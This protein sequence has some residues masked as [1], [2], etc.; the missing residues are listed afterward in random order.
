MNTINDIND[1]AA[2]DDFVTD[3]KAETLEMLDSIEPDLMTL[4]KEKG[5][6]SKE[7][8]N[9]IFR[10]IH[11]IKGGAGFSGFEALKSISHAMESIIIQ[12][13]EDRLTLNS[14]DIDVLLAAVDKIRTMISDIYNSDEISYDRELE[15][16]ERIAGR[17]ECKAAESGE[18]P[19][20]ERKE[21]EEL[22]AASDIPAHYE[23]EEDDDM[24]DEDLIKDFV[25]DIKDLLDSVEPDLLALEREREN[26]S[27]ELI[28]RVFRAM[29]S[30][31]GG[32]GFCGFEALKELS[33]A[34]ENVFMMIREEKMTLDPGKMDVLLSAID[35]IR[36]MI[37]RIQTSDQVPYV[38]ELEALNQ[39]LHEDHTA[40]SSKA[41]PPPEK[42]KT[43]NESEKDDAFEI[44]LDNQPRSV[45]EPVPAVNA[46]QSTE[47][48]K[49]P[50][51]SDTIRISVDLVDRLMNLAGE[52]VLG[53]NQL[54]QAIEGY[55]ADDPRINPIIQNVDVVTSEIQENIVQMRM[56]PVG[57]VLNKFPRTVRD[58]TRQMSKEAEMI[59]EG[60]EVELDKTILESLSNP[61]THLV[62][63]CV[64][65]GVES[66]AERLAAGKS[67]VGHIWLR[68][69]HEGGHVNIVLQDDGR[70][71]DSMRVGEIVIEK[72]MFSREQV[73]KM[74][75]SERLGLI[76]L[77]G[78]STAK[79]VTDISGRGVGMDVVKTNIERIGGH[80]DIESEIGKGTS[81]HI[82]IPLT[83]AIIPSLIVGVQNRR[84]AVPQINVQELVCVKAG[85]TS[86]QI[87]KI[88]E[89]SVLRLRGRLLPIVRLADIMG[90]ERIF[91]HPKTGEL[92][93]DRRRR[94][95]DR[96]TPAERAA[97]KQAL[98][99]VNQKN[100]R[101][102]P[103][104]RQNW[105][106]DI[107][108]VVLKVGS[109]V[110]G[111]CVDEL[112][113][114]EE[115]VVK[116]MSN[117]IKN[118]KIFA[119]ATIMGDGRV[120][121]IL[122]ASGIAAQ[123]K[124]RFSEIKTEEQRR[125]RILQKGKAGAQDSEQ[126]AIILFNNAPDEFFALPLTGVARLEIVDP[127]SIKVVGGQEFM[128]YRG[129][130][131]PLIRLETILPV[132][133]IPGDPDELFVI[134]PKTKGP[135]VGLIVSRILDTVDIDIAIT[136]HVSSTTGVAG[137][138][139]MDGMLIFFLDIGEIL[140]LFEQ[141]IQSLA[142]MSDTTFN[143]YQDNEQTVNTEE[144]NG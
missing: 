89:S 82:V 114:N 75:E 11:S 64:D 66:P 132:N 98:E 74:S 42:E 6:V 140:Q 30:I 43:D 57:N 116:P 58:L 90:L 37:N 106:S 12:V 77:P 60:G 46:R 7:L 55:L 13:R 50:T 91:V 100:N 138:T 105:R 63:N 47:Q 141:R 111:V 24:M 104:R 127:K 33:H 34:M 31:K 101:K 109:N 67:S 59:I 18:E 134:I 125:K 68:A 4:E 113:D 86:N 9:R 120:A 84:Y 26:V 143:R 83:L 54:R 92:A 32:A 8:V 144:I 95:E 28:N 41:S 139:I 115:I 110:F 61:L 23:C 22:P 2:I 128:S 135:P 118:C 126:Q 52:L 70:G 117:H 20:V 62:R 25:E 5:R 99:K 48:A 10:T 53:R 121:M 21:F 17:N 81:I 78:V 14:E 15:A 79:K 88:G 19:I 131:L 35:K 69:Y 85:E 136:R 45:P 107:Y 65:H 36:L 97:E 27:P 112:Y 103:D 122:D 1:D 102:K 133:S 51:M 94:V 40:L 124:L 72:N 38:E 49:S 71:I 93:P 73:V 29:H 44:W 130:G 87:E 137:S 119:G 129:D 123:A 142:P 16:L 3:F 96:R 80:I 76:F 108:V 39:V 56:Q